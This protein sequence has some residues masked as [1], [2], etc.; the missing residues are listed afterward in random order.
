M[1]RTYDMAGL[2]RRRMFDY[3]YK[4]IAQLAADAGIEYMDLYNLISR[5][6]KRTARIDQCRKLSRV[7]DIDPAVMHEA[8]T[9]GWTVGTEEQH[10]SENPARDGEKGVCETL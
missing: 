10:G 9:N 7:L 1:R 8:T 3:G 2:L 6:R 5:I 4:S